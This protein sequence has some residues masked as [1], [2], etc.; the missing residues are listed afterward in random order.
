ML[1]FPHVG[2]DLGHDTLLG[3]VDTTKWLGFEKQ[4]FHTMPMRMGI[5]C[6]MCLVF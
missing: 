2:P 4:P 5:L 6:K 3:K 1:S